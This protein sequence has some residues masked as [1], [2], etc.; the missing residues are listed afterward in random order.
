LISL[1]LFEQEVDGACPVSEMQGRIQPGRLGG[2][3]Q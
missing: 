1:I 2:R 3:F